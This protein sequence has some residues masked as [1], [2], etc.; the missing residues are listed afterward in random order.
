MQEIR[1]QYTP[2]DD[3]VS[4]MRKYTPP[5]LL[6]PRR[7]RTG[8]LLLDE[9][10]FIIYT[11]LHK[12]T[13]AEHPD[14]MRIPY[15]DVRKVVAEPMILQKKLVTTQ[16]IIARHSAYRWQQAEDRIFEKTQDEDLSP[17]MVGGPVFVDDIYIHSSVCE[18]KKG[19]PCSLEAALSA[20][21]LRLKNLC[22]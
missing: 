10:D 15:A 9:R 6:L 19:M 20:L 21:R 18:T 4:Y 3:I 16:Y 12:N 14:D 5:A 1:F 11:P 8:Y 7:D 17:D 13:Q 22:D 2:Y